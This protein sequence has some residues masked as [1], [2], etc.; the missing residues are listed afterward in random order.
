MSTTFPSEPATTTARLRI[1]GPITVAVYRF[2]TPGPE[3]D[4]TLAWESTTAVTVTVGAGGATGFGWSY[5][6]PAA[7]T[8]IEHHLA[9]LLDGRPLDIEARRMEMVRACRNIGT[10][11]VVAHALSAVDIALWDLRARLLERPLPELLGATR[12]ATPVYGSGGFTTMDDNRLARQIGGWQAAGC[13][14][15]KIKIGEDRGRRTDRDLERITLAAGLIG[16]RDTLMVDANGA[17]SVAAAQWMGSRLDRLGV[18]WFEEPVTSDDPA[19]LRRV[20][21]E[22]RCDVTAGEYI[23]DR[24]DAAA[25][26]DVVDCLQLDVTRCG[27][28]SGFRECAALAAAH[29]VDVSAH[30]APSLHA[31]VAAATGNLRHIEWFADH[32]RLEPLLAEGTPQVAGGLLPPRAADAI[33]NGHGMRPAPNAEHYRLTPR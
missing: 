8:V 31:P 26:I 1:E 16:D 33:G 27:G 20:R 19:G 24:Y 25:L 14:A 11:G 23:Y 12:A 32:A 3:A 29:G 10:G 18:G 17:Y 28:Y 21:A 9:P 6:S 30:C 7:A 15:V 2:P 4:G 13:T 22:V 5:T